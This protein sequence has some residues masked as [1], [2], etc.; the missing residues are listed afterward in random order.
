MDSIKKGKFQ[1]QKFYL[2]TGFIFLIN[3]LVIISN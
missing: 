2:F 1:F 3:N